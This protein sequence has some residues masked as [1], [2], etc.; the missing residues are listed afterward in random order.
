[1]PYITPNF[2]HDIFVSYA[3][4][5]A[6]RRGI[7]RL[8]F[9]TERLR[10]ELHGEIVD[11]LPEFEELDIFIDHQLDP[12]EPLTDAIRADVK[13]S[14]L[15]LIV[16]SEHYLQSVWCKEEGDWFKTEVAR[17]GYEGGLALVVRAQPTLHESW[18]D[19]LK[20]E[21]GHVVLGFQFHPNPP[22]A[23][24]LVQPYGWPE[25]LPQ[26]RPYYEQLGKLASIVT[27]RLKKIKTDEVLRAKALVP[28]VE[29]RIQ[30]KPNIYLQ[31]HF[32]IREEWN[33]IREKLTAAGCNVLPKSFV[34]VGSDLSAI[35]VA[36][37]SRLKILRDQAHV[38]CLLRTS[39]DLD[40]ENEIE[41][42]LSDR[43]ALQ[44]FDKDIPCAIL[45]CRED[46]L[47]HT[48]E[49]GIETINACKNHLVPNIQ[50]WLKRVFDEEL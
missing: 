40:I 44:V 26:D 7:K 27:Q 30:G 12:T 9:W 31:A 49:L 3:H 20:D 4:G 29:F 17:R 22:R 19:F 8:K 13:G 14:G 33:A 10:E 38:L 6:D 36:R 35:Q 43:N 11:L 34:E 42:M 32:S 18:P 28:H 15:L 25:P 50:V 41:A 16:M 45:N 37:K 24:E 46:V 21:R 23:S 48:E 5:R 1:M 2:L 39:V 47:L